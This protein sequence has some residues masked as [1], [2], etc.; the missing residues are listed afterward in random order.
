VNLSQ[1]YVTI[2]IYSA[3][4]VA[5]HTQ[6]TLDLQKSNARASH[7]ILRLGRMRLQ[8]HRFE[9]LCDA[10]ISLER[11][12][13]LQIFLCEE[14]VKSGVHER[15]DRIN[16]IF[17]TTCD[18]CLENGITRKV[19]NNELQSGILL[20]NQAWAI[21]VAQ[22]FALMISVAHKAFQTSMSPAR[23]IA[24]SVRCLVGL[25]KVLSR[26][27]RHLKQLSVRRPTQI[28]V[29]EAPSAVCPDCARPC[30]AIAMDEDE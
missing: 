10:L 14:I 28:S 6:L 11:A 12:M 24:K 1:T 22:L 19:Q 8:A 30:A 21:Q 27:E 23:S 5:Q 26:Q 17:G 13:T 9:A 25:S 29:I 15:Y 20:S 18:F 4:Q 3:A 7:L 2:R 16:V